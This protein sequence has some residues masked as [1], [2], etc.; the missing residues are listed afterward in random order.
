[1]IQLIE[2]QLASDVTASIKHRGCG[3][4]GGRNLL[5][6]WDGWQTVMQH[7][8]V[9]SFVQQRVGPT[10]AVV[11]LLYF[12]K[13]PG[14][15]WSLPLH[16]DRTIA[17]AKHHQPTKPY[18][19]PTTKAGVAH[20]EA[21]ETLLCQMLTLRVHLDPMTLDNGPLFVVPGS[22]LGDDPSVNQSQQTLLCRAGDVMAMR[23]LLSH[24]SLAATDETHFHRRILHLE[25][26][27]QDALSP[28]YQWHCVGDWERVAKPNDHAGAGRP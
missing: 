27:P 28:P 8:T 14:Q 10:A 12:D 22:H 5:D 7:R 2:E 21:D 11:R 6:H 13:P 25:I 4:G 18:S 26:A 15:G 24:G 9:A 3:G 16:R 23:P 1:M 20:V 19:K 17:V